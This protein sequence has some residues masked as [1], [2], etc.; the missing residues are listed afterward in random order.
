MAY[1]SG[2]SDHGGQSFEDSFLTR[3]RDSHVVIEA[4]FLF[5]PPEQILEL[6]VSKPRD[7][8]N[9]PSPVLSNVDR[10]VPLWHVLG[11]TLPIV[12]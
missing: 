12:T 1:Q 11:E 4:V 8:D 9:V 2:S 3:D 6:G 10:E 5:G 7:G